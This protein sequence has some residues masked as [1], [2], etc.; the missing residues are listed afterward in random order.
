MRGWTVGEGVR[1]LLAAGLT[2][3]AL[4]ALPSA[5]PLITLPAALAAGTALL[6]RSPHSA[7]PAVAGVSLGAARPHRRPGG[8]AG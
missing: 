6:A 4:L 2:V 5:G 1:G 8:P 3:A 7:T